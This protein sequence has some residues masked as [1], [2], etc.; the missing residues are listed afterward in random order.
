MIKDIIHPFNNLANFS[1]KI[2]E[3]LTLA[4]GRTT[5]DDILNLKFFASENFSF[6]EKKYDTFSFVIFRIFQN[7]NT[8][9]NP[10]LYPCLNSFRSS[11]K[12]LSLSAMALVSFHP[13][14]GSLKSL[15]S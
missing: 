6:F 1:K 3:M 2:N 9:D 11:S 12:G 10:L 5:V 4:A 7:W 15:I 14:A 8:K 13:Q